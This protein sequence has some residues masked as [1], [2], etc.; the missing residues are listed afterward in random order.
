VLSNGTVVQVFVL[1]GDLPAESW[2]GT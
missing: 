1:V 2:S